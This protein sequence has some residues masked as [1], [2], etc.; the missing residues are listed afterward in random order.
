MSNIIKKDDSG[1]CE[2][3]VLP[4]FS[5]AKNESSVNMLTASQIE[6]LQKEAYDEAYAEGKKLGYEEGLAT[7]K[8]EIQTQVEA[9]NLLLNSLNSPFDDLD[10][11]V[12]EELVVLVQSLVKQM[13]RREIKTD[14]GQVIAVIR[15][16]IES[17]PVASRQIQLRLHPED[18]ALVNDFYKMGE[19]EQA[20]TIIEDPLINRGGCKVITDITQV[21]AT[22][23]T[24]LTQLFAQVFGERQRD[25]DESEGE[26]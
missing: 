19:Q 2:S 26:R 8:Q 18:A 9:F 7:V 3:W 22:L 20:W 14:P 11:Q 15:E 12:D 1:E 6:K 10:K 16:A 24:R 13:V 5:D 25:I 23:E 4:S 17:L 21:D